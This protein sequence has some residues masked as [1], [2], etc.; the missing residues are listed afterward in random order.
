MGK[1]EI[2]KI[3]TGGRKLLLDFQARFPPSPA[4]FP[5]GLLISEV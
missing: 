3:V 5:L 1:A 2:S 4:P